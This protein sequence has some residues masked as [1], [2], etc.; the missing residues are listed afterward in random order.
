[1][2]QLKFNFIDFFTF[3][4]ERNMKCNFINIV[5]MRKGIPDEWKAEILANNPRR[6]YQ[7][8]TLEPGKVI[9]SLYL[10]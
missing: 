9:W 2:I 8:S 4:I 10:I 6:D 7:M 3:C 5:K 1:M